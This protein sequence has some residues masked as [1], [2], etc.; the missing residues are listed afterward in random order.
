MVKCPHATLR[1]VLP[2]SMWKLVA[3]CAL[4]A[5][6]ALIATHHSGSPNSA[7]VGTIV[8][9]NKKSVGSSN[10]RMAL[11]SALSREDM[12]ERQML[13][14]EL[15]CAWAVRDPDAALEWVS[16]LKDLSLLR[17]SR[18]TVCLA[19]A[20]KDPRRAISLALA[21]GAEDDDSALLESLTMQWCEIEPETVL[22][23]A[24]TQPPG[25]WR[26]RM[27]ARVSFV[28]SKS[29]PE[30]AAELV[31]GLIPGSLQDEAVM[32]VLHQWALKDAA[33]ALRWAN[34]FPDPVLRERAIAEISNLQN[35]VSSRNVFE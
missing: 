14:R 17:S 4:C 32:T 33:A 25:E 12:N 18:S 30:K 35:M 24:R 21:Y 10:Q 3:T 11:N 5:A 2:R 27:L 1:F 22:D 20:E 19:L 23:W 8:V 31:C 6:V 7:A 15:L 13:V 28:L 26:E 9:S 29:E 16:C 34:E